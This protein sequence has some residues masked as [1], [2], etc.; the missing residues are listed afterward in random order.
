MAFHAGD[1]LPLIVTGG[2]TRP[3]F[4]VQFYLITMFFVVFEI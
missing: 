2:D 3:R 1:D 4:P